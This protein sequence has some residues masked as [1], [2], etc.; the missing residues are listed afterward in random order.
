MRRLMS[1]SLSGGGVSASLRRVHEGIGSGHLSC[2]SAGWSPRPD[3]ERSSCA[4]SSRRDEASPAALVGDRVAGRDHRFRVG[5]EDRA[6]SSSFASRW[7]RR[8]PSRCRRE[9]KVFCCS[10]RGAVVAQK[11]ISL[12]DRAPRG[13]TASCSQSVRSLLSTPSAAVRPP[14]PLRPPPPPRFV[15]PPPPLWKPPPPPP[16]IVAAATATGRLPPLWTWHLAVWSAV[17]LPVYRASAC[18]WFA[19][20]NASGCAALC[21]TIALPRSTPARPFAPWLPPAARFPAVSSPAPRCRLL[22][23]ELVVTRA[24]SAAWRPFRRGG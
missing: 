15:P 16:P 4:L 12:R 18:C 1:S 17:G 5:A 2:R 23:L 21:L 13:R 24:R 9:S 8:A 10:G 20:L 11:R 3:R 14:P 7:R 19:P 6:A 22:S